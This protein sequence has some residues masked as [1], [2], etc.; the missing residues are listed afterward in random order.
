[1]TPKIPLPAPVIRLVTAYEG[2][3]LHSYMIC[4]VRR[5]TVRSY[6]AI[7]SRNFRFYML[8][9]YS[10]GKLARMIHTALYSIQR[11]N[12]SQAT[13]V[14]RRAMIPWLPFVDRFEMRKTLHDQLRTWLYKFPPEGHPMFRRETALSKAW[15]VKQSVLIFGTRGD[16]NKNRCKYYKR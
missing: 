1:M 15:L 7:L 16:T 13:R 4:I 6:Q 5:V 10:H 8:P 14:Y 11:F 2:S 12:G 9:T 3:A